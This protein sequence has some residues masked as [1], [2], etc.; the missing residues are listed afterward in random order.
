MVGYYQI[1]AG[2]PQNSRTFGPDFFKRKFHDYIREHC[3]VG[4][5]K[6]VL[7][8]AL[9]S[10]ALLDVSHIIEIADEYM[11][12]SAFLDTRSCEDT[13][14]TYLRY[15]TIFRI[16]ILDRPSSSKPV[17]FDPEYATKVS[18][19]AEQEE[20]PKASNE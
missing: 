20:S 10:G 8:I 3:M 9:V 2:H 7:E 11:L 18:A 14:H 6:K 19:R 4:E 17:G 5:N 13:Y 12:I 1:G 16:N 15:D